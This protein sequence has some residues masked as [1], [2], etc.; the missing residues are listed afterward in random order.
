MSG[1][2]ALTL[3]LRDRQ[4]LREAAGPELPDGH[5]NGRKR[6]ICGTNTEIFETDLISETP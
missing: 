6:F 5:G 2:Q 3:L 1:S 4:E